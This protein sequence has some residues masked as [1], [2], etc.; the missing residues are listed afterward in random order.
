MAC[1]S[2]LQL[3]RDLKGAVSGGHAVDAARILAVAV[4][5]MAGQAAGAVAG[6]PGRRAP[7]PVVAAGRRYP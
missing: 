4:R 1:A 7:P 6:K 2:C 3:R 5:H